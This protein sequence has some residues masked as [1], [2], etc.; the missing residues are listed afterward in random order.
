MGWSQST[1]RILLGIYLF[2]G[3]LILFGL[4][5]KFW[6]TPQEGQPE[7]WLTDE[8]ILNQTIEV[9]KEARFLFLVL[10][11]AALGSYVHAATSF[12]TYVGNRSFVESWTWW[13]ILRP[14]IGIAL[15]FVFYLVIRGGLLVVSSN[16]DVGMGG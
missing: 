4:L 5:L 7:N 10:L 2:A 12:A 6:P 15:A 16:A 13:Y 9:D 1:K 14:P 11:A 8:I 3:A